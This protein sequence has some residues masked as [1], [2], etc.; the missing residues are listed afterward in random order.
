MARGN[1]VRRDRRDPVVRLIGALAPVCVASFRL[2]AVDAIANRCHSLWRR[3]PPRASGMLTIIKAGC[4]WFSRLRTAGSHAATRVGVVVMATTTGLR[5]GGFASSLP[6][7]LSSRSSGYCERCTLPLKLGRLSR[8]ARIQGGIGGSLP[9]ARTARRA[10]LARMRRIFKC[11]CALQP[12][13]TRG[14]PK[15]RVFFCVPSDP[16]VSAKP[17][18]QASLDACEFET[19]SS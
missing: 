12:A 2:H 4:D 14:P 19:Q 11:G 3:T 15:S 1:A 7:A 6:A 16:T 18:L 17:G 9:A 5:M 8:M 10:V 13:T